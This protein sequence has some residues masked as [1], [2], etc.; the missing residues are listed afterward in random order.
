MLDH[1]ELAF[2][3]CE[4][5]I[6]LRRILFGLLEGFDEGAANK[7]TDRHTG[8]LGSGIQGLL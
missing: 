8:F 2:A 3:I 5:R 4:S 7:L 1:R 6:V